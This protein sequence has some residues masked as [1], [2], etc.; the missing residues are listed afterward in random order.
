MDKKFCLGCIFDPDDLTTHAVVV[1]RGF[2][3][4]NAEKLVMIILY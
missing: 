3:P 1:G 4:T 2:T